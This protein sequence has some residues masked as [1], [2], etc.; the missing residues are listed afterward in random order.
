MLIARLKS[1]VNIGNLIFAVSLV[2]VVWLVW[3]FYTGLGGSLQLAA[4]LIPVALVLQIL[5]LYR[6]DYLYK[7]LPAKVN[8]ALVAL[9]VAIAVYAF[10]Y[11]LSEY[12]RIAIYSQ[13]TYT[14]QDFVVGLL[15]F[16]LEIGRAHV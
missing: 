12:E 1:H 4:R 5:F 6:Q 14:Q 8:N 2:F 9:Y 13:G 15:M 10:G 3:Y 11:F 16:L 7:R